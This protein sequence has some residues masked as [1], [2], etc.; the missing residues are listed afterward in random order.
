MDWQ[1]KLRL[2]F[3]AQAKGPQLRL[4]LASLLTPPLQEIPASS[5]DQ[6]QAKQRI[7]NSPP[8]SSSLANFTEHR[9]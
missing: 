6:Q 4:S 8:P 1:W 2:P 3:S 7:L 5:F 9:F